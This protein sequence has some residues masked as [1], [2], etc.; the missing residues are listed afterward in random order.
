MKIAYLSVGLLALFSPVLAAWSKEDREIFRIRD[1]ISAHEENTAANF[2]EILGIS[3]SASQEDINKAYRKKTRALHPDKITQQLRAERAK[4]QKEGKKSVKP[5][6]R[7][8]IDAAVKSAS[9]R[10]ARLSLIANILRGSSRDRYDHFLTNGFPLWKGTDY[11]YNRYRPG[12]GTVLVGV[13]LV[14]GGAIHYLILYMNW[15]RQREF[16]E[17]YI[18]FAREKAWGGNLGIPG[19]DAA[20]A[21]APAPAEA[22]EDAGPPAPLNRR[23]RRMQEKDKSSKR[24]EGRRG[25][26]KAAKPQAAAASPE[27]SPAPTG[28][29]RRIVAEN[30]KVLIV[31]S[32]GDVYLEEEDEEGN[33]NEFLLDPNEVAPP[34]F[35]D[36]AVFQ[37]PVWLYQ[38][39]LGRFI[40]P[41]ASDEVADLID[42]DESD[43]AQPTPSSDS[44]ADDFEL[45]E[46]TDSLAKA[47]T[48]GAQQGGKASKR[49]NKKR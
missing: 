8:E 39:T 49:K 46:S 20:P 40:S 36:T 32:L 30:G 11:Y 13:F 31:D 34:T 27:S 44:A 48:S 14:G 9:D 3:R 18:K 15:R 5:L 28:P 43:G 24:D 38:L 41:K 47:K 25:S 4:A 19:I 23:Q 12:L 45:L 17:R 42:E 1:E 16:L 29:R 2:Y 21:P 22:E 6:T 33:V 35:L 10:Q 26:R 37:T 7:S